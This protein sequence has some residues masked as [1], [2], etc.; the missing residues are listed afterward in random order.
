MKTHLVTLTCDRCR[1]RIDGQ[2]SPYFTAGYYEVGLGSYWNKYAHKGE[3]ILCDECM[4][5]DPR[6]I[7]DYGDHTGAKRLK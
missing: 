2:K 7:R 5:H 4:F 1:G 6:Y 3:N